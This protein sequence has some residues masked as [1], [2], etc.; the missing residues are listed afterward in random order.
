MTPRIPFPLL[1][2]ALA[3]AVAAAVPL[4]IGVG[5]VPVPPQEV[6]RIV[7]DRL[8][9]PAPAASPEAYIVWEL[10]G[11]RAV[12]AVFTGAGLAV[13][14]AVVQA[15]VR[16]PVADPHL[17]G[18]SSGASTGAVL[19]MAAAG[20][21]AGP[22]VLPG[23]AFAGAAAAGAA[24]FLLARTRGT[25]EPLRLVL[26]GVAVGQLLGGATSF[27]VLRQ[28]SGDAQQQ[29]LFWLLGSLAG[30]RWPL[31]LGCAAAV[32]A[33]L[34]LL[35]ARAR[36]LDALALGAEGAAALGVRADRA[37]AVLFAAAAL[38]TGTVVAVAGAIGFVGLVVPNLARLLVGA[39]HRRVLPAAALLGALML[40]AADLAARTALRPTE[41]PIGILTAVV[42]VPFL[43]AALRGAR[44]GV[45][46]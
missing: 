18:L 23:A 41:L 7:A 45:G 33:L 31:A 13:A 37:R 27:L 28:A 19:A 17:L 36:T 30:A 2:G 34:A 10:R 21:A 22:L 12:Q 11:P 29:V 35:T 6:V 5:A 44:A 26:V 43:V 25:L 40:V 14:G 15:L 38:L 4:S 20:A 39:G 46:R 24:V 8:S 9:S 3:A 16:N 1:L 32:T 42:G